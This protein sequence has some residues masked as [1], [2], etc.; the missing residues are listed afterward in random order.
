MGNTQYPRELRLLTPSHF[1]NVFKNAIPAVSPSMTLLGR[2]NQLNHP[3]LGVTV[4][5]KKVRFAHD[6]N[7]L[8]RIIRES[9]RLNQHKL[10][11]IDIV[12]VV[13]VGLDK[14]SNQQI[15]GCLDKLWKKLASRC[16]KASCS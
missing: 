11:H 3:R 9:F 8:K 1:E 2:Q 14:Q 6:R 5:K 4:A 7:R 15:F 12:V 16:D 10:P 13:K